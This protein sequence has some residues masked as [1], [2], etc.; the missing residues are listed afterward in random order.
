MK[1]TASIISALLLA[2]TF[3][4][5]ACGENKWV[6]K[7][8][9]MEKKACACKGDDC[10]KKFMEDLKSFKDE[11]G[12]EKVTKGDAEKIKK[13]TEAAMKCA[14]GGGKKSGDK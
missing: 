11:A 14:M 7:A 8:Q 12:K 3:T 4:L 6:K 5:G 1:K 9:D 2:G 10:M 13:A